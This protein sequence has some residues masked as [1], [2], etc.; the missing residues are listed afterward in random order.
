MS[1]KGRLNVILLFAGLLFLAVSLRLFYLHVLVGERLEV[2]ARGEVE[3]SIFAVPPRGRILDRNAQLL[4]ESIPSWNCFLDRSQIKDAG[5]AAAALAKIL[6]V[7]AESLRAKL[8][9][10]ASFVLI[11]KGLGL[12]EALAVAALKIQGVG[13]EAEQQRSYPNGTLIQ[14][15]LGRVGA[16]GHGLSGLEQV[17]DAELRS[18]PSRLEVLRDGAGGR[19]YRRGSTTPEQPKQLVLTIERNAQFFAETALEE[20]ARA[21]GAKGAM[22]VAQDARS[23]EILVMAAYPPGALANPVVQDTFEPGST[24]KVVTALAAVESGSVGLDEEFDCEMGAWKMAPRVILHDHEKEG[25][26]TLSGILERSSNIGIAKVVERVGAER[27]FKTLRAMG[28]GVKSGVSYPG[29]AAGIM[30]GPRQLDR[31]HLAQVSFGHG[32]AV[33]AL[34]LVTAFSAIANG[35]SL[36]EPRLVRGLQTHD[37]KWLMTQE[38][39]SVRRAGSQRAVMTVKEMLFRAVETGTGMAARVPGYRVAGKT[40]TAQKLDPA[41]GAY[42]RRLYTSSFVGFLPLENPRITILVVLDEPLH[43]YYGSELAA[44]VFAKV[45]KDMAARLNIPPDRADAPVGPAVVARP[46][47]G[48]PSPGNARDPGGEGFRPA[49]RPA[50]AAR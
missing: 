10:K 37:G 36:M 9:G 28:F 42:S 21:A 22:V 38:P 11:R 16:D 1:L 46:A 4:T 20:A 30:K 49:P 2:I 23:G 3:R 8:K 48:Y 19:I 6:G 47:P 24:L 26:L 5:R 31:I 18:P 15:V 34:Q 17:F 27:F 40:G 39:A 32:V 35:G 50:P 12:D 45:A 14:N 7:S 44:P 41:T 43:G 29:E 13:L 33:T 25:L